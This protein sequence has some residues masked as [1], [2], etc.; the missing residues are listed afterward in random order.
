L[1]QKRRFVE[2]FAEP[3][4]GALAANPHFVSLA[5][6]GAERSEGSLPAL[7]ARMYMPQLSQFWF[8][9]AV[10]YDWY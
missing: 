1:R 9:A 4:I 3:A 5:E 2:R 10:R 6:L 7:S 8:I